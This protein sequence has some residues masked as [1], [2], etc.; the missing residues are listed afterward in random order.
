[1][2]FVDYVSIAR[3]VMDGFYFKSIGPRGVLIVEC[4]KYIQQIHHKH[5]D[6]NIGQLPIIAKMFYIQ[7]NNTMYRN[8]HSISSIYTNE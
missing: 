1:M 7:K 6:G 4:A 2:K 5:P 3:T 8:M